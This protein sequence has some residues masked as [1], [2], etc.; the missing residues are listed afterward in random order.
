MFR[1]KLVGLVGFVV[2]DAS[3]GADNGELND[4]FGFVVLDTGYMDDSGELE[5]ELSGFVELDAGWVVDTEKLGVKFGL[6]VLDAI[7]GADKGDV[8]ATL[9]VRLLDSF[10]VGI[11][12]DALFL[13]VGTQ[14]V[15]VAFLKDALPCTRWGEMLVASSIAG[16]LR[17]GL[18]VTELLVVTR[19]RT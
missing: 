4:E 19:F 13:L 1:G 18:R 7:Q 15:T 2:L 16:L 10:F 12:L 9:G 14:L 5:A 6:A 8:D 11:Q 17:I 3:L